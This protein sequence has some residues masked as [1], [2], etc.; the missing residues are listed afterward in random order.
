MAVSTDP[1]FSSPGR[2]AKQLQLEED[3]TA[4]PPVA[5]PRPCRIASV[6]QPGVLPQMLRQQL[7][8]D[9]HIMV[10]GGA[11]LGAHRAVLTAASPVFACMLS[12]SMLEGRRCMTKCQLLQCAQA[13]SHGCQL[14]ASGCAAAGQV[15]A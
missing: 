2:T 6:Q 13:W 11:R 12:S 1:C 15:K 8:C 5:E 14:F 4:S 9:L 7:F 10:P 3:N